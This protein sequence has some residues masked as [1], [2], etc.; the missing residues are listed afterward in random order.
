[1]ISMCVIARSTFALL[2]VNFTTK[3]SKPV[4]L[5]EAKNLKNKILRRFVPQDDEF[6]IA[7]LTIVRSQ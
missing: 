7:S 4:I 1:M 3:Q 2:S 5:S 6:K